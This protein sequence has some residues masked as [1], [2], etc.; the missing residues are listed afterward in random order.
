MVALARRQWVV[1]QPAGA[2]APDEH[3]LRYDRPRARSRGRG[4]PELGAGRTRTSSKRPV[5]SGVSRVRRQQVSAG[6]ARPRRLRSRPARGPS[7]PSGARGD[8]IRPGRSRSSRRTGMWHSGDIVAVRELWKG[9]VWKA[10]PWIIVR[11]KPNELVLWIPSG[12]PTRIPGGSGIP[13]D[14]WTLGNGGFAASALRVAR[15][16]Q[17]HSILLFHDARGRFKEWYVNLE[18]P[19]RRSRLGFDYLDRELDLLARPDRSWEWLDEDEFAEA[20]SRRDRRR[21]SH[22]DPRGGG[23]RP[24]TGRSRPVGRM[25]ARAGLGVARA[26]G[27]LGRGLAVARTSGSSCAVG[28]SDL[29]WFAAFRAARGPWTS[30]CGSRRIARPQ[31]RTGRF[32]GSARSRSR[33]TA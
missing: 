6:R 20:Q 32:T 28:L 26:T 9:R 22:R 23:T 27:R 16:G 21:R 12:A 17:L 31:A 7:T 15:P 14:E 25:A 3:R 18:R 33:A 8:R 29:P 2:P 1:R 11:D 4:R 24:L 13:R 10:R 19:L 30:T 5:G